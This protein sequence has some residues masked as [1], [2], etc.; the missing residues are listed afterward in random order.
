[1]LGNISPDSSAETFPHSDSEPIPIGQP[2]YGGPTV[3]PGH[4]PTD[5]AIVQIT[6]PAAK[7]GQH[8]NTRVGS[9]RL[10]PADGLTRWLDVVVV[11][12]VVVVLKVLRG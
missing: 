8:D 2:L 3:D 7:A 10:V 11:D 4:A 12:V 6:T 1:M 5:Q 9:G